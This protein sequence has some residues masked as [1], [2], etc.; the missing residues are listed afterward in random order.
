MLVLTREE[1]EA[2]LDPV[3]LERELAPA[4]AELSAGGVSMPP[5]IAASVAVH[6][7]LLGAMP[8]FLPSTGTL[9]A[10][11]VTVFPHN[12]PAGPPS[13][14]AVVVVFDSAT[15]SPLCLMDGTAITAA[16]TAAA[17]A[18]A[19]RLLA[20]RDAD[21]LALV[22]TGVQARAHARAL[23]PGRNLR[24]I[25]VL[26]RHR[27]RARAFA[28]RI[29]RDLGVRTR[30]V[31][32]FATAASGAGIVCA[33]THSETPVV[34]GRCLEPGTH[35]NSVGL[36]PRGREL[37]DLAVTRAVVVVDSR[38]AA[39]GGGAGGANDLAWPLREGVIPPRHIRAELGEIVSGTRPGR[40][41]D[42]DITLYKSVGVAVQDA[43]AARL[44]LASARHS[45]AGRE[46]EL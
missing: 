36:N 18:L 35:V 30:A 26:G 13:H 24:E 46:I 39:L 12:S 45:G 22:G 1:V 5:R 2:N 20:R 34:L 19:T 11:L 7:A 25:R 3:Q 32:D 6:E 23:V 8:V 29:E 33:A 9:A 41:S 40:R 42:S 31:P 44:V 27:E 37:D 10:K 17:S 16:R 38:A 15:G 14:Q 21:V 28:L 43:V 4:M